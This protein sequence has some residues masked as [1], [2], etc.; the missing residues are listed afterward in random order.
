M[1]PFKGDP[2]NWVRV[3]EPFPF[4]PPWFKAIAGAKVRPLRGFLKRR[5]QVLLVV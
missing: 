5:T 3:S 2:W 1:V 4:T